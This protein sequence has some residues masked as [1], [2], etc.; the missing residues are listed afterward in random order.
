M[1]NWTGEVIVRKQGKSYSLPSVFVS[2]E[3]SNYAAAVGA[4]VRKA[5]GKLP[6]GT[7]VEHITV[8]VERCAP[9]GRLGD[10]TVC[11]EA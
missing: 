8:K 1:T 7:R 4:V 6:K 3:A 11:E 10:G 9:V 2:V 5:K